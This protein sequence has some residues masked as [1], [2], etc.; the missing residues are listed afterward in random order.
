[1]TRSGNRNRVAYTTVWDE[2]DPWVEQV[3]A[4][5]GYQTRFVIVMPA[6]RHGLHPCVCME[7]YKPVS[8]A[9]DIALYSDYREFRCDVQGACETAALFLI[10]RALMALDNEKYA[11]EQRQ[12]P[13]WDA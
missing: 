4:E 13:L 8:K 1:M 3:Y 11:A 2:L 6:Q 12:A 10:S 9:G 7:L 5:H